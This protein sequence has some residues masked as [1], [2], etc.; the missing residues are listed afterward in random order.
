MTF[1]EFNQS[2]ESTH[3]PDTLNEELKALWY[4]AKGNWNTAHEIAQA[5]PGN[6]GSW[7]HAYLHR[8]EGDN[9][10]A[11]YWYS[12]AGK[13]MPPVSLDQEWENL[14]NEFLK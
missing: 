14:V 4:D 6:N 7:I 8:E 9:A 1:A 13:T 5:I 3:P 12:R 11:N 10:N 2:L